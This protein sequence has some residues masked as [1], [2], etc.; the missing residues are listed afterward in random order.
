MLFNTYEFLLGFLPAALLIY[1]FADRSERWRT[2]VL[3]G[4]SLAFYSYWDLRFLPIMIGSILLNWS[5]AKPLE[6]LMYTSE[7]LDRSESAAGAATFFVTLPQ[8]S[9][10]EP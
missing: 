7:N 1:W 5:A 10:A 6:M 3:I 9:I 2:W 8:V 4:L